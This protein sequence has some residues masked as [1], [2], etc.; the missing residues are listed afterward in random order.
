MRKSRAFTLVEL[1]VVIGIIALLI[2][3]L[4]PALSS[5]RKQANTVKCATQLREIG[6]AFAL[7]ATENRQWYPP[8]QIQPGAALPYEVGGIKAPTNAPGLYWFNFINKYVTRNTAGLNT[9]GRPTAAQLAEAQQVKDRSVIW[10]CAAFT[11]YGATRADTANGWDFN[12]VQTG[13]GMNGYPAYRADFPAANVSISADPSVPGG[14]PELVSYAF[15]GTWNATT[16]SNGFTKVAVWAKHA[17]EKLLVCDATLWLVESAAPPL[18]GIVP[19]HQGD[20][21]AAYPPNGT[22]VSI[23]RHGAIKRT[24]G[25]GLAPVSGGGNKVLFNVLY[26]DGHVASENDPK[27]AY[28]AVRMKFPG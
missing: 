2:S 19:A 5:A 17:S 21:N 26:A 3:I 13:Y 18:S 7:Y 15:G 24:N 4:L 10:G 20:A 16:P 25:F 23:F 11:P 6:N 8:S 1:L 12:R 27:L 9:N 22:F 14:G 28:K